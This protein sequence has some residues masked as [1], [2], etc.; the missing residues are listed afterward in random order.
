MIRG[1]QNNVLYLNMFWKV[2]GRA[3][4]EFNLEKTFR[5]QK[6]KLESVQKLN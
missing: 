6:L 1:K 5:V 4:C 2:R 3:S